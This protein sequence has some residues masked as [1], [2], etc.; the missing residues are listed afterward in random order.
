M[1]SK[2]SV[3]NGWAIQIAMA[4]PTLYGYLSAMVGGSSGRYFGIATDFPIEYRENMP[5]FIKVIEKDKFSREKKAVWK[6][7]RQ[8]HPWDCEVQCLL[9]A[10]RAGYF[11]LA[12]SVNAIDLQ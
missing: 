6:P 10:I 4:N 2:G 8:T 9:G 5:A 7:V 3:P 11:P 12:G 1:R